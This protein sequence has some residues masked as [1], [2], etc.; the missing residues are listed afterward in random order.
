[1]S[2]YCKLILIFVFLFAGIVLIFKKCEA[3]IRIRNTY[4]NIKS[5][6]A[7]IDRKTGLEQRK[8]LYEY[9]RKKSFWISLEKELVYSGL[10]KRFPHLSGSVFMVF[11]AIAVI[12]SFVVGWGIKKPLVGI[13]IGA[14]WCTFVFVVIRIGRAVNLKRVSED[15]PKFLDFLGSYSLSAGEITGILSQISVYLNTPV[16]E[17]VEECVAESRISGNAGVALLALADRIEHPQFK[18]LIRNIEMTSRY[19]ADFSTLVADSKRSLRDYLAQS[20]ERKG[21][22]R[23]AAINM[24]LLL[25]MSVVVLMMVNVLIGGTVADI[26]LHSM[27]GHLA[28]IGMATIVSLFLIQALSIER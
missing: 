23:E 19:S 25:I 26:I 9:E 1:M 17:A 20:R 11:N 14:G 8:Q 22:L 13:V 28:M 21:M 10:K 15:L 5:R 16:R 24:V 7:Q 12:A 27:V 6:L 4:L 18:L 3:T 2:R